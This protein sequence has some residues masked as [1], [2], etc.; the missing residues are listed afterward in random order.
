VGVSEN[1]PLGAQG[2][3]TWLTSLLPSSPLLL[4]SFLCHFD[5]GCSSGVRSLPE[6]PQG[7]P[8]SETLEEVTCP[9]RTQR[10]VIMGPLG[11]AEPPSL[12]SLSRRMLG[13]H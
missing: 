8:T 5:F 7:A 10:A 13:G 4:P 11:P 12:L 3:G 6:E 2:Q 9:S 1:K